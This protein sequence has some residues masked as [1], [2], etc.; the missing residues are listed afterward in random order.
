MESRSTEF[1]EVMGGIAAIAIVA[2]LILMVARY[3]RRSRPEAAASAA[4]AA[5]EFILAVILLVVVAAAVVWQF[6]PIADQPAAAADWRT[7]T[8][9]LVFFVVMLVVGGLG[10]LAFLIFLYARTL[11]ENRAAALQSEPAAAGEAAT[12]THAGAGLLGLL[13]LALAF[14]VLNWAY[15]PPEQQFATMLHLIYPA[16]LGTALVLLLDKASRAWN[17][18]NAGET[19]REWLMCDL[20][21]FLF[22]LG[23]MNL[24]W[25]P[26]EAGYA[27]MFWDFLHIVLFFLTFWILDRT[28]TR[29]R[30]LVAYGYLILLPLLLWIW[31]LTQAVPVPEAISWWSS[32]WPF[33]F[34]AIVFFVLEVIALVATGDRDKQVVPAIKDVVF[35]VL[36]GIL[37]AAAI[38]EAAG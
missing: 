13:L 4:P 11:G 24:L 32:I 5:W 7:G 29:F 8:R 36:Y 14:L 23:F 33:F 27:A 30:F 1:L 16:S 34:L 37:L 38:P 18:K 9:A 19:V 28:A 12:A 3:L 20:I 31:R 10:L 2:F 17:L 35:L 22:L 25:S 26:A 6:A 15:L 21:V